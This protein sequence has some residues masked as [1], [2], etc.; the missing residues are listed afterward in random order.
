PASLTFTESVRIEH[1]TFPLKEKTSTEWALTGFS[2]LDPWLY[3]SLPVG[4]QKVSGDPNE[5]ARGL[6]IAAI[7]DEYRR[8]P[9]SRN[10]IVHMLSL[11]QIFA[12]RLEAA[13][14]ESETEA[15]APP[16]PPCPPHYLTS[17]P[18]MVMPKDNL[19]YKE[20]VQGVTV[21]LRSQ[22]GADNVDYQR[23]R[24]GL[25]FEYYDSGE[26]WTE[27]R[28]FEIP[29]K[30]YSYGGSQGFDTLPMKGAGQYRVKALQHVTLKG[31][32]SGQYGSWS[33]WVHFRIGPASLDFQQLDNLAEL[34]EFVHSDN[35]YREPPPPDQRKYRSA[36]LRSVTGSGIR[37]GGSRTDPE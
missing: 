2:P 32:S 19:V 21:E 10:V 35:A 30:S 3:T 7:P 24:Y 18:E 36:P 15:Q 22:C 25:R 28:T 31:S 13:N 16:P 11:Q 33:D 29:M 12:M 34:V 23:S 26:G 14:P 20:D 8:V 9:F 27:Y 17:A 1:D 6:C 5:F 37:S 4:I